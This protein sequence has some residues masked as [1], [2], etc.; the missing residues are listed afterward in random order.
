[1]Y[2]FLYF[3][4]GIHVLM[5]INTG[6]GTSIHIYVYIVD[7]LNKFSNEYFYV[8]SNLYIFYLAIHFF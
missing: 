3:L 5:C 7:P 8:I 2:L 1:M 4:L 6:V